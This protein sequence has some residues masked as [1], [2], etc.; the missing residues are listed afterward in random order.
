MTGVQTCA[1]PICR[2]TNA[3]ATSAPYGSPY[4]LRAD[5]ESASA[6]KP[7]YQINSLGCATGTISLADNGS[8]LDGGSFKLNSEGFAEDLAIQLTG[9]THSVQAQYAGD[10]SYTGSSGSDAITITPAVTN[11]ELGNI[12]APFLV[13]TPFTVSATAEAQSSGV[14]PS[15]TINFLIDGALDGGPVTLTATRPCQGCVGLTGSA[16]L[17]VHKPGDHVIGTTYSGDANYQSNKIAGLQL[18]FLYPIA[19]LTV[20][21]SPSTVKYGDS[22]TVTALVGT[23]N[24][25]LPPTGIVTFSTLGG[26]ASP[27]TY[28]QTQDANGNSV[29]QATQ[30]I[31]PLYSGAI[32]AYFG[33]DTN[34]ALGNSAP[35]TVTVTNAPDYTLSANP[36]TLALTAG[37]SASSTVT[38]SDLNGF[39]QGVSV[40]CTVPPQAKIGC[41][42]NAQT[43]TPAAGSTTATATFTVTTT[44]NQT[45]LLRTSTPWFWSTSAVFAGALM[46]GGFGRRRNTKLPALIVLCSVVAI[47]NVSCGG[48]AGNA[49]VPVT[50]GSISVPG[51]ASGTY[52]VSIVGTATIDGR[53]VTHQADV[54]VSIK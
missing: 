39:T 19:Y 6:G 35:A 8:V 13:D 24:K 30:Q 53:Q 42:F 17:T 29:L 15:G 41:T 20:S 40:I 2:L 31:N 22:A 27:V 34:Y 11:F 9:G 1:L 10:S 3:N 12:A 26:M 52:T 28:A 21:V 33:G 5:V 32:T 23:T 43:L 7:C 54:S 47:T 49:T 36:A 16:T 4:I 37:Q 14:P 18:H 45:A 51:T 44:G 46:I 38:L 48:A 50:G 25:N